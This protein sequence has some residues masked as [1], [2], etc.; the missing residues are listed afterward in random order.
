[1]QNITRKASKIEVAGRC[2]GMDSTELERDVKGARVP[3]GLEKPSQLVCNNGFK[4][5][6]KF[7][8]E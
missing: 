8:K 5:Q 7:S 2:K 1:M 4:I 3:C 6:D